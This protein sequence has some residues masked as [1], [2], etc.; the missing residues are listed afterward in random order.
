M[1]QSKTTIW[2]HIIY[3][4]IILIIFVVATIFISEKEEIPYEPDIYNTYAPFVA[5][6]DS[7]VIN[8][9]ETIL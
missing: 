8:F 1:K 2:T 5:T 4:S 7:Y 3:I 9:T 6:D